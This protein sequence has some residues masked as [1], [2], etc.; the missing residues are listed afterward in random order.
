MAWREQQNHHDDCYFCMVNLR[1]FNRYK[2]S[3][4]EYPNLEPARRPVEHCKSIPVPV[5]TSLPDLQET[6]I[7]EKHEMKHSEASGDSF[8]DY[9]ESS[10]TLEQY[11]K[12]A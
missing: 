9:E 11:K 12:G 2:R 3:T 1:G 6:D 5:F 7:E 4:W 10:F 8:S